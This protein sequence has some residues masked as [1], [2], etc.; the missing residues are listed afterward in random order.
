MNGI[1]VSPGI[2]LGKVSIRKETQVDIKKSEAINIFSEIKRLNAAKD[3]CKSQLLELYEHALESVGENEAKIFKVHIMMLDDPEFFAKAEEKIKAEGVVAEYAL[4]DVSDTL[5]GIFENINDE[6]MQAR[7]VDIRD[8][9]S[10]LNRILLG[11]EYNGYTVD[12]GGSI[13]IAEDLTPSDTVQMDRKKVLGFVT[14]I[15][16]KTSHSAIL[17]RTMG[18]PA[19]SGVKNIMSN[20]HDGDFIIID[21]NTGEII[22]N[23]T[24]DIITEYLNKK[25]AYEESHKALYQLVG[26]ESCTKDGIKVE[27]SANI[28]TPDDIK[29][30]LENDAEGIGL[31][32]T[33]FLY[34][35]REQLP[36]EEELFDAFKAV[37]EGM[38]GKPVTIRTF[39]IGGDKDIPYLGLK[40]ESNPFLGY[41]AIRYCLDREDLFRTQI[42]AIFRASVF[43]NTKIMFPMIS[44]IDEVIEIKKIIASVKE[45]LINEGLGFDHSIQIG[46]M[47]ETPSAALISDFLAK[48]VDFFSIGT[49]DLLQYTIAVDRGNQKVAYLYNY[50]HPAL[51]RL[52]KMIIDNG[53]A[54]NI[55]VGMCG[56]AAG[57]PK[58]IPMLTGMG[59]DELSMNPASI[60]KA[61]QII[62]NTSQVEMKTHITRILGMASSYDI[63]NYIT[64]LDNSSDH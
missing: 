41:R 27:L 44:N 38:K 51:L 52:V 20:V 23:P 25:N 34:M 43:G 54:E 15:G 64:V 48:E 47:I 32:R 17:A 49:N 9:V 30:V 60:L 5:I 57:D 50:Y 35:D 22:V 8:V 46:I 33:E 55:W 37:I 7:A 45:E 29:G 21:G 3:T 39:D 24:P 6:Y 16:G 14:E 42:R 28:G 31:Y 26:S 62:R 11:I 36:T 12:N 2:A 10:R 53:H 13:I 56:E 61:R 40:K 18:I 58:L 1:P 19:V 4:K 59:I 63:E